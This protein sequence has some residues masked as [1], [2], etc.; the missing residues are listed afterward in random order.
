M[1][2]PTLYSR[3]KSGAIMEWTIEIETNKYRVTTGEQDGKKVVSEWTVCEGKNIGKS[4]ETSPEE[5]ALSEAKAKWKK[6]TETDYHENV[7][8]VDNANFY[9]PMLAHNYADHGNKLPPTV[10]LSPKM[11]GIRMIITKDGIFSR[12]GKPFPSLKHIHEALAPAF[13][14]QPGLILD[15]EAY[16]HALKDNFNRIVKLVKKSK[17]ITKEDFEL[18]R[19]NIQA[20]LFDA[21]RIGILREADAYKDR[22]ALLSDLVKRLQSPYIVLVKHEVVYGHASI[23]EVEEKYLS[24]GYEGV[25][26]RN[27]NAPYQNDRSYSLQKLKRFVDAEYEIVDVVQGTGNRSGGAGSLV[28]RDSKSGKLFDANI[29]GNFEYYTELLRNKNKYI[30]QK[31]TVKYQNLTPDG[32]PRFGVVYA[33]RNYE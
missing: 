3:K 31:A 13:K 19:D 21:P 27:P 24:E 32:V 18:I 29:K 25:M 9:Q 4:N 17:R 15:G 5:Q 1:K 10:W 28:L 23:T 16:N 2:L 33:I 30:G 7:K 26:V 12:Q 20:Y 6:K 14:T 11:D 8:D 22:H